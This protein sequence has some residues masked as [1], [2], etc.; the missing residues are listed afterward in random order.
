MPDGRGGRSWQENKDQ[1]VRCAFYGLIFLPYT[2][3]N[4]GLQVIGMGFVKKTQ[5]EKILPKISGI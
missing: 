1:N 4:S 5:D 3:R 2:W